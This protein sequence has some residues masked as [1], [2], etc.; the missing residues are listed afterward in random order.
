MNIRPGAKYLSKNGEFIINILS[1]HEE[2]GTDRCWS[3]TYTRVDSG[4][5]YAGYFLT[6]LGEFCTNKGFRVLNSSNNIAKEIDQP[7]DYCLE[8]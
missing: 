3:V 6:N 2:D 1:K 5:T 7:I 4:R 8:E